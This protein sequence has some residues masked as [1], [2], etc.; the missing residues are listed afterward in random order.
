MCITLLQHTCINV[1][2]F[3]DITFESRVTSVKT[4]FETNYAIVVYTTLSTIGLLFIKRIRFNI[5]QN[6]V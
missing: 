2:C 4:S 5:K 3:N 6:K 1:L